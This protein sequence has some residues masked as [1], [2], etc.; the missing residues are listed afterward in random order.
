MNNVKLIY[1]IMKLDYKHIKKVTLCLTK[2]AFENE[3][4]KY[5]TDATFDKFSKSIKITKEGKDQNYIIGIDNA[6]KMRHI[7]LVG[8]L[9]REIGNVAYLLSFDIPNRDVSDLGYSMQSMMETALNYIDRLKSEQ[10]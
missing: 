6:L 3:C 10:E 7:N 8:L 1:D 4:K 9:T 5:D 2:E